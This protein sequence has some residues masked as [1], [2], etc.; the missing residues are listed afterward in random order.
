MDKSCSYYKIKFANFWFISPVFAPTPCIYVVWSYNI[1]R[2]SAVLLA[3][4]LGWG[5]KWL[6]KSNRPLS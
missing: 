4:A 3:Q 1:D 5:K 2:E 6:L